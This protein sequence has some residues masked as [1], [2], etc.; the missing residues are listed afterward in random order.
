LGLIGGGSVGFGWLLGKSPGFGGILVGGGVGDGRLVSWSFFSSFI[1]I[2]L[3]KRM[4]I[5]VLVAKRLSQ[6]RVRR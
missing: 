4:L 1:V 6:H 2:S 3:S 5:F